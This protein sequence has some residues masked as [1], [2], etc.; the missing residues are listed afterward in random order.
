VKSIEVKGF[1][2]GTT[3]RAAD[4]P[5]SALELRSVVT[6]SVLLAT[7]NKPNRITTLSIRPISR[8]NH[9]LKTISNTTV[10]KVEAAHHLPRQ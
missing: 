4:L 1:E 7:A 8:P 6:A 9:H 10:F 5:V 2:E 3:Q